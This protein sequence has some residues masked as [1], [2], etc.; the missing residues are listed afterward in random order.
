MQDAP[1]ALARERA[2]PCEVILRA[3]V[4]LGL[5][6]PTLRS[7]GVSNAVWNHWFLAYLN[8]IMAEYTYNVVQNE[9]PEFSYRQQVSD[10]MMAVVIIGKRRWPVKV[11]ER[12]SSGFTLEV[13]RKLAKKIQEETPIDMLFDGR[14]MKVMPESLSRGEKKERLLGISTLEEYPEKEKISF[15]LWPFNRRTVMAASHSDSG[16]IFFGGSILFV[17]CVLAMPG[18][19]DALGTSQRI[20]ETLHYLGRLAVDV[21]YTARS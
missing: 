15:G 20:E 12:Y 10:G 3:S 17:F 8:P 16:L 2:D 1:K 4:D 6:R 21:A 9:T 7:S 11:R 5:G 19:G 13:P 14:R 18:V